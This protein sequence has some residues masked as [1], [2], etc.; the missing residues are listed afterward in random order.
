MNL[1]TL[2]NWHDFKQR[3]KRKPNIRTARKKVN[4]GSWPGRIDDDGEVWIY[5]ERF[6]LGKPAPNHI[7]QIAISLLQ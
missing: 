4:N 5:A 3:F 6:E 1:D 7:D 2:E